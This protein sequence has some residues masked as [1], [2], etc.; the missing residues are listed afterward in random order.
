MT[1][2][3][4]LSTYDQ[5]VQD[6]C[7]ALRRIVQ[8]QL[9]EMEEILFEGW[10]SI[11]YGTGESRAAK[12]LLLYL[13]PLKDSVNLGFYRGAILPDT[14]QLLT[15][16]GKLLRHLKIKSLEDFPSEDIKNLI[17]EAKAERLG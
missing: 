7:I 1:V 12:D 10:K 6:I 11:G 14:K 8:E 15:G 13:G 9:P 16:T 2:E 5:K 17:Q 3:E 4:F